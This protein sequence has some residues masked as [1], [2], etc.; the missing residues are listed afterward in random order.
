MSG[1][2]QATF[3]F[4]EK[5][6]LKNGFEGS[7]EGENDW[8]AKYT[9][10]WKRNAASS[11]AKGIISIFSEEKAT[12]VARITKTD[13]LNASVSEVS[14]TSSVTKKYNLAYNHETETQVTKFVSLNTAV[15]LSYYALWGKIATLTATATIGATVKF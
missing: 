1:Y 10:V 14:S 6:Y 7:L 12:N 15:G 11:L 2:F 4:S 9:L 3:Y 8:K 5:N 13:S